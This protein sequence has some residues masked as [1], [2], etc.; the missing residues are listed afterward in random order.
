MG[1]T[2]ALLILQAATLCQR[3]FKRV[4]SHRLTALILACRVWFGRFSRLHD[5]EMK[6]FMNAVKSFWPSDEN[7]RK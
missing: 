2:I 3:Y 4:T 7:V 1:G 5:S 6:Y